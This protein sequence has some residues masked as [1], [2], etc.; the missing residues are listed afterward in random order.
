MDIYEIVKKLVGDIQPVGETRTDEKRFENLG[1]TMDLADKLIED[2]KMV[3]ED[4]NRAEF[5][6]SRAGKSADSF[7]RGELGV[8]D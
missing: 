6:M 2:I 5:S 7:L 1:I 3:A 4:K 8:I